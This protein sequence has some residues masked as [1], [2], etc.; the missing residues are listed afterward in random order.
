MKAETKNSLMIWAAL[1]AYGI[2]SM[3]GITLM[4]K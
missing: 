4:C 3:I 2:I 1:V